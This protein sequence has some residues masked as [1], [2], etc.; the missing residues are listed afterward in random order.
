MA[1]RWNPQP[2]ICRVYTRKRLQGGVSQRHRVVMTCETIS[3]YHQLEIQQWI[4]TANFGSPKA[5]VFA[6]KTC[7]WIELNTRMHQKSPFG[8][9][10]SK[11]YLGMGTVPSPVGRGTPLPHTQFPRRL[12]RLDSRACGAWPQPFGPR[13]STPPLL[14]LHP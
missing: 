13:C 4:A 12:R 2:L 11:N 10:K 9:L 6:C 3:H 7:S 5:P 1:Y 8:D 14:F